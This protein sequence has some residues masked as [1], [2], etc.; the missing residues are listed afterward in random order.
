MKELKYIFLSLS[1]VA[2]L[3]TSSFKFDSTTVVPPSGGDIVNLDT[4]QILLSNCALQGKVCLPI[5][6]GD[7]LRLKI[8]DNGVK[9]P[10]DIMNGCDFDSL[11]AYTY[12]NLFG[13]GYAGPYI[14]TNWKVNGQIFT[15]TFQDIPE[16][17]NLMNAWD[18]MGNWVQ[19][20]TNKHITGGNSA[21]VYETMEVWVVTLNSPSIIGYN[22][23]VTPNGTEMSFKRGFHEVILTDSINNMADTFYV[24]AYCS[25]TIN[26]QIAVSQTQTECVATTDLVGGIAS[27]GYCGGSNP[28][29]QNVTFTLDSVQNCLTYQALVP[30]SAQACVVLCDS[31][32]FCDTT[33]FNITVRQPNQVFQVVN[34]IAEGDT[35]FHCFTNPST[36]ISVSPCGFSTNGFAT[37][38]IDPLT[39]C[40]SIVGIKNGGADFGCVVVCKS[41]GSC[42]TTYFNTLVKR[43]GPL[44]LYDTVYVNQSE[45]ACVDQ[46]LIS[47][48]Q[49][50]ETIME[51][52]ATIMDYTLDNTTLCFEYTGLSIGSDTLGVHITNN[53]GQAD[54]TYLILTVIPATPQFVI[55]TLEVGNNAVFC[56]DTTQVGHGPYTVTNICP[57]A[58]NG[59]VTFVLDTL[60][61]CVEYTGTT[62][63]TDSACMVICDNMGACD[64]FAFFITA[65]DT[66]PNLLPPTASDD[67]TLTE[68]GIPVIITVLNNDLVP[69]A[70]VGN[71][72]VIPS[73]TAN[74]NTIGTITVNQANNSVVYTPP[75]DTCSTFDYFTYI[76]CNAAGC[77]TAIVTV[78]IVCP[79]DDK[80]VYYQ[81]FSPNGDDIND[82][83]VIKNA[84]KYPG[85]EVQVF[86]RWGNK[87]YADKNYRNSWDGTWQGKPLPDGVYFYIFDTG[88]GEKHSDCVVIRR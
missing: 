79:E 10:V 85:N 80:L 71:V 33:Y 4:V 1:I 50:F 43:N 82:K 66:I 63:G 42:D 27:I 72:Q 84:D 37:Y 55:D 18:P 36:I 11:S 29:N 88:K 54:T 81:G 15:D 9:I 22:L 41:N 59:Q 47:P 61:L 83:F 77:D 2:A 49:N 78:M 30:G 65:L 53:N 14:L 86:N 40:I 3:I 16:L 5:L 74:G 39:N 51:P 58:Q 48:I 28:S 73:T 24:H 38:Q 60:T 31:T 76:V 62:P 23:G 57:N 68:A 7:A 12:S 75:A 21:N 87:V 45:T 19:N 46:S 64:T 69:G 20:I 6:L 17:V 67:A 70:I 52:L 44:I 34:T 35:I 13:D 32:G 8:T 26:D 25:E 56:L